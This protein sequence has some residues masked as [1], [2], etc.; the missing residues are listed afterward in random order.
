MPREVSSTKE[1]PV[2][3]TIMELQ[4]EIKVEMG[5]VGKGG[6]RWILGQACIGVV[7]ECGHRIHGRFHKWFL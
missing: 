1:D 7:L 3:L 4:A 5:I 6:R 2:R